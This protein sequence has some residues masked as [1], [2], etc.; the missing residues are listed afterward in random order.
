M[1]RPKSL[2]LQPELVPAPLWGISAYR[3][4][5]R[6]KVW[7]SI[8]QDTLEAFGYCCS[9]CGT[10]EPPFICHEMWDYDD[11]R[12]IATLYGFECHCRECDLVAHIG[13]S[14]QLG[15]RERALKQLCRVNGVTHTEAKQVVEHAMD[16][17]E[18][19]NRKKW[20]IKVHKS[21]LKSYPELRSLVRA[22]SM[23]ERS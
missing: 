10:D 22:E 4:L 17:W 3:V 6:G 23:W 7:K 8:R 11:R 2:K 14:S 13:R 12:G 9:I 19:R 5:G 1:T 18:H 21:L 20:K 15:L 16:V